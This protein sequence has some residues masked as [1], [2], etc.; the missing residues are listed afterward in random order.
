MLDPSDGT[1]PPTSAT[2]TRP[3]PASGGVDLLAVLK[4]ACAML[5][6]T[7]ALAALDL[8]TA[9]AVVAGVVVVAMEKR[10][11]ALGRRERPSA[12]VLGAALLA[13]V[14]VVTLL[15]VGG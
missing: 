2:A 5:V 8:P 12:V 1:P 4:G 3:G 14:A 7:A 9:W 11:H 13:A 15:V 10:N 6:A